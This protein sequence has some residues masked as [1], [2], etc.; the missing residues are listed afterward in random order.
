MM[1][2]AASMRSLL[3]EAEI[4]SSDVLEVENGIRRWRVS[5]AHAALAEPNHIDWFRLQDCPAA[6]LVKR[7]SQRDVWHVSV[8]GR[9]YF[10]K[11]YHPNGWL[12][13]LKLWLLG[14]TALREWNV[15]RYA[16]RHGVAA[17]LPVATAWTGA[18]GQT[19]SSLLITE[20]VPC[21]EPLNEHWLKIR[22]DRQAAE[23]LA[24]SLA[25]LIARAHQCGF[26]HEDMH[27]GNIL[28]RT[29]DRQHE[30]F[31]VDLQSVR[32]GKP[33]G[34]KAV[35][36]N[37]AQL[38]QWFRRHASR[39]Q[40]RRFLG[41][42]LAYR[43]RFAQAS[44]VARN[45]AIEPAE[46]TAELAIQADR[47]AR[48]LWAKRDR[49]TRRTGRYF[50]RIRPA[51]GWRGHVL[52]CSKHP[53]ATAC[54]ARLTFTRQ[55]WKTWLADPLSWVD[56][57]RRV[58]MK[59]SHTATVCLTELP[60][61]PA[62]VKVIVKRPLV[63]N[64]AKWLGYVLGPSR[65][66]R[67]WRMTNMLLNRNLPAAQP[68]AVLERRVA[69][70]IRLDSIL[71]TDY[72]AGSL[73]LETFLTRAVAALG[74]TAQRPVKDGLIAALAAIIKQFHACGFVHRDFKAP[75]LLVNWPP[76]YTDRP[77][78][79]LIDMDGIT[80]VRRA[81]MA[82]RER[83]IVRLCASLL[84]C[85]TCTRTDRL[86]FLHRYLIGP[87]RTARDWKDHWR[88]IEG[89][90]ARKMQEKDVRRQW[91]LDRYGRE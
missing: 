30:V 63:R 36:A 91:K 42:Y 29:E 67:S 87:G 38:N 85:P 80:H 23:A 27:P 52:L 8:G 37:L 14:A 1:D 70:L 31:F 11:L 3:D 69:G 53:A 61:Q 16:V 71:L 20:A 84:N 5:R 28:V 72:V 12:S 15:G 78:F 64:L 13:R 55:Q 10:A 89:L 59:D 19:G 90:V 57:S 86:R 25:R 66:L 22:D 68:L 83:A 7:N 50:A 35:V 62:P 40:L 41:H 24:D 17:V 26:Q 43:D 21:V 58:L 75:N 74:S 2:H 65:N 9:D 4:T 18:R 56:P 6:E 51:K 60:T 34:F 82:Q 88:R 49:R 47:H 39:T 44:P 76:P 73:D 79:T 45:L 77:E 46:L 33:V 32:I 81:S 48:K 54:A